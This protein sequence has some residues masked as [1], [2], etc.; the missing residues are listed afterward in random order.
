MIPLVRVLSSSLTSD[1]RNLAYYEWPGAR[2][3]PH[4]EQSVRKCISTLFNM[5]LGL[6]LTRGSETRLAQQSHEVLYLSRLISSGRKDR[7]INLF[8]ILVA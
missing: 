8:L 7:Y 1:G 6:R 5:R 3:A 4:E 2:E